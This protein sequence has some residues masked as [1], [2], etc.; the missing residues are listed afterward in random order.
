MHCKG[1]FIAQA[2][3]KLS[4]GILY[5][6]N[7]LL[8]DLYDLNLCL[9]GFTHFCIIYDGQK[10]YK[11]KRRQETNSFTCAFLFFLSQVDYF[12]SQV[13]FVISNS[14]KL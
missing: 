3:A 12:T 5:P 9:D 13:S 7:Y 1:L 10:L 8:L 14:W 2:G 11:K 4:I 6:L